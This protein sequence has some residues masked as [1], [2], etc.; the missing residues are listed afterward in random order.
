VTLGRLL[1]LCCGDPLHVSGPGGEWPA[2]DYQGTLGAKYHPENPQLRGELNHTINPK[3]TYTYTCEYGSAT[4]E[5]GVYL[6]IKLFYYRR[7]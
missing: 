1:L 4:W 2:E 7:S 5:A 6:I 3:V